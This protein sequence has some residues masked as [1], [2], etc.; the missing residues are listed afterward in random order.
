MKKHHGAAAAVAL[1]YLSTVFFA[2]N[3]VADTGK[4]QVRHCV[5]EAT[6]ATADKAAP[7]VTNTPVCFDSIGA[8]VAHATGGAV[9]AKAAAGVD[10]PD[11]LAALIDST[12]GKAADSVVIGI[13]Y[14]SNNFGGGAIYT[15]T[16][17]GDCSGGQSWVVN[18]VGDAVNDDIASGKS[19]S[20]CSHTVWEHA[21]QYGASYGPR[22]TSESYGVLDEEITSLSFAN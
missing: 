18:N 1:L 3:A 12:G 7:Q 13:F 19:Y 9:S 15:V 20:L 2:T 4:D 6:P 17:A 5:V 14:D 21:F 16:A 22:I 11:E 8:G 10:S